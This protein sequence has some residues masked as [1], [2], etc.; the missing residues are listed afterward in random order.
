MTKLMM[1]VDDSVM[2][3]KLK[4]LD[5][6]VSAD[7]LLRSVQAG[8]M[9]VLDAAK[10]NILAQELW[11]TRTLSRSLTL[12]DGN[13]VSRVKENSSTRAVMEI[14]TNLEYAAIHEFGGVITPKHAKYLAIPV[15]GA[16]GSP[17]DRE[18]LRAVLSGSGKLVLVDE[19]GVQF[20]L[21]DSVTIPAQPFVRPAVDENV[22]KIKDEIMEVLGQ[23][24]EAAWKS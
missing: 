11:E 3:K 23:Q 2:K 21:L 4:A 15:N 9:V 7:I 12:G 13:N 22:E 20:V 19:T 8:G 24:V 5:E 14:G 6:A 10:I 16:T 17:M 1:K 18:D